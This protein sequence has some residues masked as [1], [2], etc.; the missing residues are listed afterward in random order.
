MQVQIRDSAAFRRI[1]PAMLRA[2]LETKEWIRQEIW[3]DSI[4][5][6]AWEHNGEVQEILVPLQEW[7]RRYAV[8]ISEVVETLSEVE[9][10]SQLD[11]FYDLI[12]AGADV[13]RLQSLNGYGESSLS[14]DDSANLLDYSRNLLA[15]SARAAERPGL[16]VYRGGVSGEVTGY[17]REVYPLPG[18]GTGYEC[19]LHSRIPA[20]YGVQADLGD[21]V[22]AP[23][24][25]RATIALNDGLREAG[26]VAEAVLGGEEIASFE[27]SVSQGVSAN[28]LDA[29]AD[30]SRQGH[31]ISVSLAWAPVRPSDISDASDREFAFPESSA[32]VFVERAEWLRQTSPFRDAHV[33]G[34]VVRLNREPKEEFDGQAAVLYELDGRSVA[35]EIRFDAADHEEVIRAFREGIRIRVDGDIHREGKQYSLRDPRNFAIVA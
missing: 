9:Q 8:R 4:A 32:D 25:R 19:T 2:Y 14:L 12:G 17:L 16:P 28:F 3:R 5:V 7:S 26:K 20:G 31:G 13:I 22:R 24:A 23:F 33:T 15:A 30:L 35:L 21:S 29:L 1:S 27:K 34:E 18:Y 10:R 6:W 11:V